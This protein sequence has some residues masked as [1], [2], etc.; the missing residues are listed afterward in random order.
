MTAHVISLPHPVYA[1]PR[2]SSDGQIF[3]LDAAS[4]RQRALPRRSSSDLVNTMLCC[5]F[6]SDCLPRAR[7]PATWLKIKCGDFLMQRICIRS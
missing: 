4:L 6:R 1:V 7:S 5:G 3:S 2:D